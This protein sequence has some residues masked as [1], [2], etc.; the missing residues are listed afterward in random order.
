MFVTDNIYFPWKT[1]ESLLQLLMWYNFLIYSL[2]LDRIRFWNGLKVLIRN[3]SFRIHNNCDIQS[4][5]CCAVRV[6][7]TT[8]PPSLTQGNIFKRKAHLCYFMRIQ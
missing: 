2:D 7:F 6:L 4:C 5:G 1:F 3:K 8:T